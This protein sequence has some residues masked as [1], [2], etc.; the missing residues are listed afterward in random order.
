MNELRGK[1]PPA[2]S[3]IRVQAEE[4]WRAMGAREQLGLGLAAAVLGFWLAWSVAIAPALLTLRQVPAQIEA[5]DL[6]LQVMQ[7]LALETRDLRGAPPVQTMQAL[8][9]LRSATERLGDKARLT[10]QGERSTVVLTGVTGEQL[11]AWLGE[12]RS[13]ARARP[14]ESQLTR[15]AQGYSGT[16]VVVL[17]GAT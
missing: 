9:A 15:S 14:V 13:G 10:T 1:M 17:G 5:L 7:R 12:V 16:L 11:R 3:T 4:R 6:Q 2:L 8:D